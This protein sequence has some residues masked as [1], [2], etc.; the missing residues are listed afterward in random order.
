MNIIAIDPGLGGAICVL[1][2][3][4]IIEHCP[5]PTVEL[6]KKRE[7]DALGMT[8]ILKEAGPKAIVFIEK[9]WARPGQ[10]VTSMFNFGRGYGMWVGIA[11]ALGYPIHIVRPQEWKNLMLKG[12]DKS[13]GAA[14]LKAKEIYPSI[15]LRRTF[16]SKKDD[17]GLAESF[18][19][20]KYGEEK[21]K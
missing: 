17:D 11:T 16:R 10:G 5:C 2:E 1:K 8:K 15:N 3:G 14:I 6:S 13:K 4:K 9:V 21:C 19:I 12:T 18:L 20:V 7:Y